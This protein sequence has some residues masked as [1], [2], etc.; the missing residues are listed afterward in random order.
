M[1]RST[2]VEYLVG[3][4]GFREQGTFVQA[5]DSSTPT[6]LDNTHSV[7]NNV[8][9]WI[10]THN[11]YTTRTKIYNK[12]V[13]NFEAG[14]VLER[15]GGH[16]ADYVDCPNEH[17]RKTFCNEDVQNRGC[18]RIEVSLYANSN[19]TEMV[20]NTHIQNVLDLVSSTP[21]FVVQPPQQQW[22]N[23]AKE[24]DR[25]FV[26]ADRPESTIYVCWYAHTKTKR[27]SGI[28]IRP[29][30]SIVDNDKHWNQAILWAVSDFGFRN[31]PIFQIEI[32]SADI[33][34]GVHLSKLECYTKDSKTILASCNRP[35]QLHPKVEDPTLFLP[36]T[37][38][39][40]WTW[41]K[42]KTH[43]IGIEKPTYP[44][45]KV[46]SIAEQKTV[47]LLSTA[48]RDKRLRELVEEQE[49]IEWRD[50]V[51][52]AIEEIRDAHKIAK[53]KWL[54]E[55]QKLREM[56][57]EYNKDQEDSSYVESI[58]DKS[59]SQNTEHIST[60]SSEEKVYTILGYRKY[61]NKNNSRVVLVETENIGMLEPI[62]I[63]SN[64]GLERL[65][66]LSRKCTKYTT[67]KYNRTT[68]WYPKAMVC[69]EGRQSIRLQIHVG[70]KQIY[71]PNGQ[72]RDWYPVQVVE[73]PLDVE[74]D[75]IEEIPNLEDIEK[76]EKCLQSTNI[77]QMEIPPHT[78][79]NKL[80]DV[81]QEQYI[82]ERFAVGIYRGNK[83]H[84]LFL[85]PTDKN[86]IPTTDEEKIVHGHFLEKEIER[87]G[88][89]ENKKQPLLCRIGAEKK[90]PQKKK[91]RLLYIVG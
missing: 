27:M 68:Y 54:E 42:K 32:L 9:T 2:L 17:L 5:M 89:L 83:K 21:L 88:G 34:T 60:I 1:D 91:D 22:R 70:A 39:V 18:T 76:E 66:E 45:Q 36:P 31:C 35:C 33:D 81:D 52:D 8:C 40:E 67:D 6:I 80:L 87:I 65:L 73:K 4:H 7:G 84:V 49:A 77:E 63:W 14:N 51:L 11:G 78:K 50:G 23:L 20:A 79:W 59:L 25:C 48:G 28:R 69:T 61:P 16:L 47:S 26:L 53:Q 85:L 24:L 41:R 58:V 71:R 74:I 30:Q 10:S 86:G 72:N 57:V 90:T 82:C 37:E 64:K 43:T 38:T 62:C 19:R 55:I 13:S 44:I 15:F 3:E 12:V 46:D 56:V 75:E 29:K